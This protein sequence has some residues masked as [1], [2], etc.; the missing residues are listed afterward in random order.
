[1]KVII[2]REPVGYKPIVRFVEETQTS[3]ILV[4]ILKAIMSIVGNAAITN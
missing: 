1:V 4:G 2:I 3:F